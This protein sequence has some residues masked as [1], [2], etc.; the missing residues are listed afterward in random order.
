MVTDQFRQSRGID[1]WSI[2]SAMSSVSVAG[3]DLPVA[4]EMKVLGAMIDRHLDFN[5]HVCTVVQSCNYR[6]Q[7]LCHMRHL[8]TPSLTQPLACRLILSRIHYCILYGAP[9]GT[10][11][12]LQRVR[13]NTVLVILR[14]P[15]VMMPSHCYTACT[16][17]RWSKGLCTSWQWSRSKSD[18]PQHQST[19]RHLHATT[20]RTF[21]HLPVHCWVNLV[22]RLFLLGVVNNNNNRFI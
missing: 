4:D 9:T 11:K 5:K 22:P 6:M 17:C 19:C 18:T 1:H 15:H 8:I 7:A 2:T 16:G 21:G 14:M 10:V 12:K 13:N 3:I 20:C